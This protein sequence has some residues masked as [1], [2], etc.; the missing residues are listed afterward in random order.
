M[1]VW[2]GNPNYSPI[3]GFAEIQGDMTVVNSTVNITE[4]KIVKIDN[5]YAFCLLAKSIT[6]LGKADQFKADSPVVWI[7]HTKEYERWTKDNP[8][9]MTQ[10]SLLEQ[11]IAQYLETEDGLIWLDMGF[12]GKLHLS[13]GDSILSA[14]KLNGLW[15]IL[16][17]FEQCELNTIKDITVGSANGKRGYSGQTEAQKLIERQAF[18]IATAGPYGKGCE[19]LIS[20]SLTLTEM[21]EETPQGYEIFMQL[22]NAAT[23]GN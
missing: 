4:G 20:L 23:K 21:K 22:L 17:E 5:G 2:L 8:K 11:T 15:H 16:I 1:S 6:D 9:L 19:D 7:A 10:P 3:K 13:G 14:V 12:K 18:M